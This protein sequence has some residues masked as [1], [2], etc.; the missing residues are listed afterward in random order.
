MRLENR[1]IV[2]LFNFKTALLVVVWGLFFNSV[3]AQTPDSI[4]TY[5]INA[6]TVT[7]YKEEG[8]NKTSL[9]VSAL[10]I[11]SLTRFGNFTLTDLMAR[12]PGVTMLSTGI[13]IS[14][15]VIRG[16]YGNRVLVLVSGL[17]FDNQQWQEE[18]GLGMS[19]IGIG[20]VEIIKGPMSVLYGSE[21]LGGI[22]NLIE[23]QKPTKGTAT[24]DYSIKFNS[25]TLGGLLQAGYKVNYGKKWF[26]MRVGTDNH[27]DYTNGNNKRVLNSRF[28]GYYLKASAGFER[29]NWVSNNHYMGSFSRFGFIFNDIYNFVSADARQSRR[30]NE[31]PA[32]MVLLNII[33]SENKFLLKNDRK[34]NLNVGIQSNK[35]MENEGGGAISLNMHLLT[36]QYLLKYEIKTGKTGKFVISNLGAFE[37]NTNFGAR[38][39]VP[40]A[41]M[42]EE[43]VSIYFEKNLK[44][45]LIL[46]N[47]I[48]AGEKI[49]KTFFTPGVNSPEKDIIPFTK[50]APYFNVFSGFSY[51]KNQ[52]LNLKLNA[53]TGVRIPNLAEL[54]SNGL[55]EGVFT[56]EIGDPQ[57]KNEQN[58]SLN[59][60]LNVVK[61]HFE[62]SL[63]PF[64][65]YYLNYIYLAPTT[66]KWFGFP[67]YR[68]KQQNAT[69]Y[70]TE[71]SFILKPTASLRISSAYSGMISQTEDGLYTPFIP[72]QKIAENLNY[73]L[74]LQNHSPLNLFA[75]WDYYFAQNKVYTNEIA[76]PSYFLINVGVSGKTALNGNAFEWSLVCNN[77]LN[78]TYYDHLS[79]FKYYGLL[80]PGRNISLLLKYAPQKAISKK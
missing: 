19:D 68:F 35:R 41:R 52:D 42:Y 63:T 30:L 40:D 71:F 33:S 51:S 60:L 67:V 73:N 58:L 55:H 15:P 79:R 12:T 46:E 5:N 77:L 59:L 31:N 29:K 45:K 14:K 18:H 39:I 69:Q 1:G 70:G 53:A 23:E 4:K 49:I 34:L 25:N 10:K 50:K 56:Y 64:Y 62:V 76:T 27:A 7:A 78:R 61:K 28:D 57:L 47:G 44:N 22:I 13:G 43:N 20:K 75:E 2:Y 21:A 32:H 66:E 36:I 38:K 26:R 9:N 24:T 37:D 8:I 72:A 74:K 48:G 16:L 11:D 17:R 6:V 54:S 65:N 3:K 80:N